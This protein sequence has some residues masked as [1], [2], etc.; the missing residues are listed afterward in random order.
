MAKRLLFQEADIFNVTEHQ[1]QELKAKFQR[2][3]QQDLED[4]SLA[5]R[6]VDEFSITVPALSE[7]EKY[8]TTREKQIDVSQDPSRRIRDRSRPFYLSGTEITIHV[9]FQGDPGLFGV[10]PTTSNLNPP[11]GDIEDH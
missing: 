10:Q 1:K 2:L 8:T 11:V 9:P 3:S 6:L 7:G 4:G 5:A